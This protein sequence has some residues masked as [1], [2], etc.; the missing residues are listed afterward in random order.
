MGREA[1]SGSLLKEILKP[2]AYADVFDYPLRFEEI[3]QFL[4]VKVESAHVQASLDQL[5][6]DEKLALV[7]GYYSLAYKLDLHDLRQQREAEAQ[8]LWLTAVSYGSWVASLPFVKMVAVTGSL[9]VNN[10]Q[11]ADDDIDYLVVT[12]PNR[13]WLCRALIILMVRYAHLQGIHLCPNYLLTDSVLS[14]EDQ[15]LYTARELSQMIPLYGELT[16]RQMRQL[17][18]WI[19]DY[20]PQG[21]ELQLDQ[22]NDNLSSTQKRLKSVGQW[23]LDNIFGDFAEKILQKIQITKH[24]K[25]AAKYNAL[26][27]VIF[28]PDICKGHYDGHH[29]QTMQAYERH[30]REL[31]IE[32]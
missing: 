24:L 14:F 10:P 31:R 27:R 17:N 12:E 25:R 18:T 3:Y 30:I 4:E 23:M 20:L 13:L 16:Y 2:I 7:D 22:L 28:T 21:P 1:D 19:I 8:E 26:D 5:V 29:H 32:G 15:N 6:A 11:G 9:A